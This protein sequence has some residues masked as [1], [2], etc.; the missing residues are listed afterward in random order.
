MVLETTR[1]TIHPKDE[2][3]WLKLRTADITSTEVAA[4]F[5]ISPYM[6]KFELWHRKKNA[7]VVA[8]EPT[9][10]MRWG[11][12]LQ[13]AIAKGIAEDY[14]LDIRPMTEYI[15][16]PAFRIGSSF[17]YAEGDDGILEV[18]N[19]DSL[20]YKE[21]WLSVDEGVEAP[22]HMELQVQHQLLTS[23]RARSKIGALIGGNRITLIQ[24]VPEPAIFEAIKT[25]VA[26]F[27]NS[28]DENREPAPD[29]K[30]DADFI[31]SM[32]Q[33]AEPGKILQGT[34]EILDLAM[35]YK[36]Y[37]DIAKV[38]G[39]DADGVKAHL[40]TL[41]GDAE[42]VVHD[43]FTISANFVGETLVEAFTKKAFRNFRVYF[44]KEK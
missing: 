7:T 29:F 33:Y 26:E 2:A 16:I 9:E 1:E 15:R 36:A 34:E 30:S 18:K 28:I 14:K 32:M 44:K 39:E 22:P 31:K 10:R 13:E 35:K 6:T 25:K 40:L 11:T 20:A 12:R 38:A 37:R 3:A 21:G 41:I 27:W 23:G 5:G 42:K 43:K 24:R 17:D 8:L 4:L 19:V